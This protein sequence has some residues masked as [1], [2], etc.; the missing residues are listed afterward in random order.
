MAHLYLGLCPAKPTDGTPLHHRLYQNLI[1]R[2]K[3]R[4]GTHSPI[5]LRDTRDEQLGA[6]RKRTTDSPT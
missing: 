3:N 6:H 1:Y 4:S 2:R 5:G